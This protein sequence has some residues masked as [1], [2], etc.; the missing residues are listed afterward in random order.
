[1]A[2]AVEVVAAAVV[3]TTIA[4]TAGLEVEAII[5]EVATVVMI[6]H[7]RLRLLLVAG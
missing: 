1:M 6:D 2:A 3:T 5:V 4:I 7:A